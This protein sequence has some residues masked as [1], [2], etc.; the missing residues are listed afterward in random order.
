MEGSWVLEKLK[1][2]T[3][4]LYKSLIFKQWNGHIPQTKSQ[5]MRYNIST[6]FFFP[7]VWWFCFCFVFLAHQQFYFYLQ[8]K[9]INWEQKFV[10]ASILCKTETYWFGNICVWYFKLKIYWE[11]IKKCQRS[12]FL[13]DMDSLDVSN[14][15][16]QHRLRAA[17]SSHFSR[18]ISTI[19]YAEVMIINVSS[20]KI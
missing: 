6:Q 3:E 19:E 14:F 9:K 18:I 17:L 2:S 12:L 15:S 16:S 4:S 7:E 20:M 11:E 8:L 13:P 10:N 5:I 1:T